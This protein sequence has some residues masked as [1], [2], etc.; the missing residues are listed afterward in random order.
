MTYG[1]GNSLRR[2]SAEAGGLCV[3][4]LW[5]ICT[6]F[7]FNEMTGKLKADIFLVVAI[8]A[9]KKQCESEPAHLFF[10]NINRSKHRGCF[11]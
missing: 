4:R 2:P 6:A 5:R 8:F 3:S 11:L 10:W 7:A 9:V 1:T